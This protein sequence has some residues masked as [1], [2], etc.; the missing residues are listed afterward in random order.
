[1]M[2]NII[3]ILFR[4]RKTYLT[5]SGNPRVNIFTTVNILDGG[6]PEKEINI[7]T[8]IIGTNKIWL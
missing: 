1:M 4:E 8:D 7:I 3:F 6:F 2:I 5:N